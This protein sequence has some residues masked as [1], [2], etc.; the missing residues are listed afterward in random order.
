MRIPGSARMQPK[1]NFDNLVN[2]GN[3]GFVMD[4]DDEKPASLIDVGHKLVDHSKSTEFTA[5]RGL[6]I[7]LFPF[8]FE[9][10]ERMSARAISRFLL[11]EQKIK[12]S[13]VTITKAL[14][15]PVKSWIAFFEEIAPA[16]TVIA[17]W[18]KP[19]SF[20]FLFI[21][22]TAYEAR[23]GPE[24]DNP[25]SRALFRGA[26]ALLMPAR[27]AADKLLRE[28]WFTIGQ[29]TRLKAKPHLEAHL[30][31]LEDKL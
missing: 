16:A 5:S 31:A 11:E 8:I 29:A 13:A 18:H 14:N 1:I 21:S 22:K 7:E 24:N 19:A 26:T 9:A 15:D 12:L 27:A 23:I 30:M 2:L 4:E 17:K 10:S 3:I 6:V 28:K 25:I 20:K